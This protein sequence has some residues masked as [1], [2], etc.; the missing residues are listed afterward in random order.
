MDCGHGMMK[1]PTTGKAITTRVIEAEGWGR[2]GEYW[3]YSNEPE[4]NFARLVHCWNCH[5]KLVQVVERA[6]ECAAAVST[7][8]DDAMTVLLSRLENQARYVLTLARAQ[9]KVRGE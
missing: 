8:S 4:E 3:D 1:H 7:A 6:L 9:G 2:I 5:D